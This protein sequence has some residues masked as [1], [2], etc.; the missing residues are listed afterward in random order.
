MVR[1]PSIPPFTV[2]RLEASDAPRLQSLFAACPDYF[3]LVYG[4]PAGLATAEEELGGLP[5]GKSLEDK[6]FLG[7]LQPDDAL[8]GVIDLVRDYPTPGTWYLGL[9]LLHPAL[10]G[11]G[12]GQAIHAGIRKWV[13]AQGG[14]AIRLGVLEHNV[15][16]LAFWERLGYR[17][18]ARKPF[19]AGKLTHTVRVM[20]VDLSSTAL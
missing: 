1:P 10:R 6:F 13:H 9:L 4:E 20:Q 12:H 7:L 15:K 2:L 11:L 14:R 8:V 3:H 5:P 19:D 16:A 17:E 18:V